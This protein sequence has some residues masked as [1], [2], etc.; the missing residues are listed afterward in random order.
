MA[1]M[2]YRD[3]SFAQ[4]HFFTLSPKTRRLNPA[5]FLSFTTDGQRCVELQRRICL[6]RSRTCS[7]SQN[8]QT[9]Q[10][11]RQATISKNRKA[12]L[13]SAIALI[14]IAMQQACHEVRAIKWGAGSGQLRRTYFF[15]SPSNLPV[16]RLM[17]CSLVQAGQTIPSYSF[18]EISGS[19]SN[20][21]WTLRLVAGHLK[22][23]WA[24]GQDMTALRTRP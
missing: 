5:G 16:F 15:A 2:S 20:W 6:R 8:A 1:P 24:I 18:S 10:A 17:K 13:A 21:C 23:K 3:N 9:K 12:L 19:P 7:I 22:T 4:S 11:P 14:D